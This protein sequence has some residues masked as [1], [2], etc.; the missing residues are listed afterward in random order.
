MT[1]IHLRKLA[2]RDALTGLANRRYFDEAL[3]VELRRAQRAA[4]PLALAICDLD[5]FKRINDRYGH[6][7]GDHVLRVVGETVQRHC[8][9][10]ADFAARVGG[11]ELALLFPETGGLDGVDM[12]ERL[13]SHVNA[14]AIR[15]ADGSPIH[16]TVSI[17]VTALD[18]GSPGDAERLLR[19]AD[20][21]LYLAKRTGRNRVCFACAELQ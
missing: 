8:H 19:A 21:A 13:R 16:V 9:R 12:A 20:S 5:F 7:T 15:R 3:R 17:G 6:Q 1:V 18:P 4:A 10:G 2:F 14:L 11:E